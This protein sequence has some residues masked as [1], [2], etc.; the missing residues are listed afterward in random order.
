TCKGGKRKKFFQEDQEEDTY[1]TMNGQEVFRF[2]VK[3]VPECIQQVMEKAGR[4]KEE[5]RWYIL[6]QANSRIIHAVA[7][8]LEEPE[9]KFPMNLQEYGNTSAASIPIL[10][11]EMN[12]SGK[13]R[14]G[15]RVILS[16]FGAGLTWAAALLTW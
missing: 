15:D 10:L 1:L 12:K 9:E 5:I 13:L 8:R 7:K 4:K 3:K 11:D 14:R 2:A 16:G 6:H